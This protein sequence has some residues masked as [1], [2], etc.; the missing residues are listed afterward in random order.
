MGD[1]RVPADVDRACRGV[2]AVICTANSIL[3]GLIDPHLHLFALAMSELRVEK[4]LQA[5]ERQMPGT[6]GYPLSA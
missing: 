1:L 2:E 4:R 5:I 3:P 6:S